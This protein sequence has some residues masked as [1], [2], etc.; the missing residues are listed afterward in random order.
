MI[1][2]KSN[3]VETLR[4]H[5]NELIKAYKLIKELYG[6]TIEKSIS[7]DPKRFWELLEMACYYHDL[8]KANTP[9]Q[10]IIRSA[11]G[12]KE[13][14]D[15]IKINIPHNY[16][17]PAF[18]PWQ[19]LTKEERRLLVQVIGYH[20]E[21]DISPD[22][23]MIK[24]IIDNDLKERVE[25]LCSEMS[26]NI[27][28]LTKLYT[29]DIDDKNRIKEDEDIYKDYILM[30]GLL[31][32]IDHAASAHHSIED[33]VS[34]GVG[35]VTRWY[36]ETEFKGGLREAQSF[37]FANRN[38][39]VLLVASTG[40]G[41]TESALLWIDD[42]KG[43][44][45]LPL[46]VSINALYTRVIDDIQYNNTGL[47]HST[48]RDYLDSI[49]HKNS[50]EVY[51]QSKLLSKKLSFSTIDQLFKFPFKYR[52]YEKIY[53]TLAYSKVVIDEIQAYSPEITAVILKGLEMIHKI[54]GRFMIMTATLPRIYKDYL[55]D[56][57]IHPV[58]G[59]Y[60]SEMKRHKVKVVD[61]NINDAVEDIVERGKNNRAIVIVNTVKKALEL[62]NII[63]EEKNSENCYLLHSMFTQGDRAELEKQ[64]KDF[65]DDR[66][67]KG[68]KGIWITTQIVEA[69]L[70]V[71]FDYLFTEISTLDSMF[72]RFGRCYRKRLFDRN[73]PN[74]YIYTKDP[75]GYGS[76]YDKAIL[77]KSTELIRKYDNVL[78]E[79]KDKVNLVDFLYSRENLRETE[80]YDKFVEAIRL[81][82]NVIDYDLDSS[83][84]QKV[85]RDIDSTRVI[86]RSIYDENINIFEEY[87][88]SASKRR[89]QI[90]TAINKLSINV[91][92][93]KLPKNL[94]EHKDIKNLYILDAEYSNKKGLLL[95][96]ASDNIF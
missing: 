49:E 26:L 38:K 10:N 3:P 66:K 52:G 21:R 46:R 59:E 62:F 58:E 25:E 14:E 81:L 63:N 5:T 64:I 55:M 9:F 94:S 17:S 1:Y 27:D 33:N 16:L 73:E 71:D 28:K 78:M 89:L 47:I 74:V 68:S 22:K 69:S 32:R 29:K 6:E 48:S 76:I 56:R 91:P 90:L 36:L 13:L 24:H 31:H 65:V 44:F 37:A 20:H 77:D 12:E 42:S 19:E 30:K 85:L 15:E 35:K 39:N 72:Q 41:K 51:E 53:A 70:D 8:G 80:F 50:S 11:I 61:K 18:L 67:N 23:E 87:T 54:G 34:V 84:A 75:T 45:T 60:L 92:K 79:E 43:F 96:S 82:D 7:M 40:I 95:D 83:E 86:P 93:Y 2:A 88:S 57:G 4:Q